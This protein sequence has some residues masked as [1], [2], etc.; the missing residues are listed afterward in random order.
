M[1]IGRMINPELNNKR[2][3]WRAKRNHVRI[4]RIAESKKWLDAFYTAGDS[5]VPPIP[6]DIQI[7]LGNDGSFWGY[8]KGVFGSLL[9]DPMLNGKE[10]TIF[11]TTVQSPANQMSFGPAYNEPAAPDYL[12]NMD[13]AGIGTL[14][15][16]WFPMPVPTNTYRCASTALFN[17]LKATTPLDIDIS[18]PA[19]FPKSHDL[20]IGRLGTTNVGYGT[21]LGGLASP[22]GSITPTTLRS[23]SVNR[24]DIIE[25]SNTV[26]MSVG[27]A[28]NFQYSFPNTT[29]F[30]LFIPDFQAAPLNLVWNATN[31]RYQI[32]SQSALKSFLLARVGTTIPILII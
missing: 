9:G 16:H 20:T 30:S 32:A 18:I 19:V 8:K 11:A 4:P 13:V 22:F 7:A 23:Q 2:N 14:L 25:S 15:F 6:N 27:A 10:L 17:A 12:I 29:Y 28:N 3:A 24:F 1:T 31:L 26:C 21:V 5:G